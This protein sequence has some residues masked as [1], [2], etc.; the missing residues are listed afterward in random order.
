M[1]AHLDALHR[2]VDVAR[3]AGLRRFLAEHVPRLDRVAHLERARRRR[4]SVPTSGQRSSTNGRYAVGGQRDA[5]RG[6]VREHVLEVAPHAV[7]QQEAIVQ[8]RRPSARARAWYG[9]LRERG[10]AARAPGSTCAAAMR[11][12][13]GISNA[14]SSTSPCRPCGVRGSNSLSIEISA[15][16]VEPATS[17]S[18]WRNS[19]STCHGGGGLVVRAR[20]ERELE[21]VERVVARLVDARRLRRRADEQAG[22]H[23]RQRRVV[24]DERDQAREQRRAARATGLL[25]GVGP[26]IVMWLPPPDAGHAAV[27]QVALGG[28]PACE[29]GVEHGRDAASARLAHARR[30]AAG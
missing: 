8:R 11:G 26:P 17:T 27:E 3:G 24:L 2:R 29:R 21:L 19:A 15:R 14:R 18:R 12:C 4:S 1:R 20:G 30:P 16:W 28:E 7:R 5:A 23:V 10:D 6:E 13:G 25:S 22:E 9:S